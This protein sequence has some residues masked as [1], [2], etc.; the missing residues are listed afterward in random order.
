VYTVY[1]NNIYI[2]IDS[3]YVTNKYKMQINVLAAVT[4]YHCSGNVT[5]RP[6][7]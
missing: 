3:V 4:I 6:V 1:S 5:V 7:S 2:Y